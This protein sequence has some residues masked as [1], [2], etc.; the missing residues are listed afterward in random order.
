[1]K[2]ADQMADLLAG[3]DKYVTAAMAQWDGVMTPEAIRAVAA[4]EIADNDPRLNTRASGEGRLRPSLIGHPCSRKQVLS[5]I[6]APKVQKSGGDLMTDGTQRHY[7]W[8]KAGL[9]AGWLQAIEVPIEVEEWGI[10]GQMDGLCSDGSV[11]ELKT[12]GPKLYSAIIENDAPSWPHLMQVHAYMKARKVKKASLVYELRS[13]NV[14]W[15]EFRVEW[16]ENVAKA[17]DVM[18]GRVFDSLHTRELPPMLPDC[19]ARTGNSFRYC[20]FRDACPSAV[21]R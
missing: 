7:Y 19:V 13:F 3:H 5:W 8:Q 4:L 18:V 9:S 21:M 20:E 2:F 14:E 10:R 17:L 11:F 6:G 16:D 12:T 1:M 15:H